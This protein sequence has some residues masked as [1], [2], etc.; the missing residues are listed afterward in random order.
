MLNDALGIVQH[1]VLVTVFK[2]VPVNWLPVWHSG[3]ALVSINVVTLRWARLVPGWVT[4]FGR[5]NYLGS[6]T[7]HPGQLSLAIP[8][9]VVEM[10]TNLGWG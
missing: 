7:S 2:R 10:S 9:W 3:N 1:P 6:V 4:V 8:P 5:V